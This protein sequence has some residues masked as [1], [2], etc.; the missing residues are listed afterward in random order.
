M[1]QTFPP[2]L[3]LSL[4]Y[5]R[6]I[7]RHILCHGTILSVGDTATDRQGTF[8]Y[9]AYTSLREETKLGDVKDSDGTESY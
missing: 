5:S 6:N 7:A 2:Q 9:G 3:Y 4:I 1:F 8:S